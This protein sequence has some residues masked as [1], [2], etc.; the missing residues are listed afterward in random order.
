MELEEMPQVRFLLLPPPPPRGPS[1]PLADG[2]CQD[3]RGIPRTAS[4]CSAGYYEE[5]S[6]TGMGARPH[7]SSR[8]SVENTQPQYMY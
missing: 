8:L 4:P 3:V 2:V 6:A 7:T 1:H 5:V